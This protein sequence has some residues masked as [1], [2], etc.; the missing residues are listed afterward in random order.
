MSDL[1]EEFDLGQSVLREIPE[2]VRAE[3]ARVAESEAKQVAAEVE[4][5]VEADVIQEIQANIEAEIAAN[6]LHSGVREVLPLEEP[7][8]EGE[9]LADTVRRPDTE[10][11]AWLR[12][13]ETVSELPPTADVDHPAEV[14]ETQE[15]VDILEAAEVAEIERTVE[16]IEDEPEVVPEP[17]ESRPTAVTLADLIPPHSRNEEPL[18]GPSFDLPNVPLS[19][20]NGVTVEIEPDMSFGPAAETEFELDDVDFESMPAEETAAVEEASVY[21]EPKFR[22]S[23]TDREQAEPFVMPTIPRARKK[24]SVAGTM[25]KVARAAWSDCPSAILCCSTC[26]VPKEICCT[27]LNTCRVPSF[28][29]HCKLRQRPL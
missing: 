9:R 29:L 28:R 20:G 2:V 6:G 16:R 13:I 7:E 10:V 19:Y 8:M 23:V 27:S 4:A 12:Q 18:P 3:R 5:E 11:R 21:N 25:L 26:W 1:R 17:A 24:R 15:S 14:T 22:E